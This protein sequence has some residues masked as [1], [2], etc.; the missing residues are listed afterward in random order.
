MNVYQVKDWDANFENN[1]SRERD[2]C[3]F[4]CVPN[5]QHGLGFARVVGEKDGSAIYGIWHMI[6]GAC[7][8]QCRPRQ[9]WLTHDGHQTGTPWTPEELS[10]M[11]RRP[12]AEIERALNFLSSEKVGWL[13]AFQ[14]A[15]G[16]QL[17]E[18]AKGDSAPSARQVPAQ[19]PPT[20]LEGKGREGKEEK[21]LGAVAP[22]ASD[23]DEL[24]AWLLGLAKDAAYDGIDVV[25]EFA[26]MGQWCRVNNKKASRRR[27]I[28]WL[29]RCDRALPTAAGKPSHEKGF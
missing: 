19:C 16:G 24:N 23:S 17:A 15:E 22:S 8:R 1:K 9:G 11:F 18:I 21:T 3:S 26:R 28:N 6:L 27:F 4:V 25:R 13:R 5:K 12:V 2:E 29:N 10:I 20:A 7:S 14:V